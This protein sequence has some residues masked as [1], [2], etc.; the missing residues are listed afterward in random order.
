MACHTASSTLEVFTPNETRV[1]AFPLPKEQGGAKA[2]EADPPAAAGAQVAAKHRP[3]TL[4]CTGQC[5]EGQCKELRYTM[6]TA[7]TPRVFPSVETPALLWAKKMLVATPQLGGFGMLK[8]GGP[9]IAKTF[10]PEIFLR[11]KKWA[12]SQPHESS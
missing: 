8:R 6:Y 9:K 10:L 2:Y 5:K 12:V 3:L 1:V 4:Y 11:K 7:G